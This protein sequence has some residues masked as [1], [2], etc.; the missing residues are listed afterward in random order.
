[1]EEYRDHLALE[2]LLIRYVRAVDAPD[3]N[4]EELLDLFTEDATL[5]GA[6][7]AEPYR[8]KKAIEKWVETNL[9]MRQ[10]VSMRHYVSNIQTEVS[11]DEGRIFAYLIAVYARP[12]METVDATETLYGEYECTARR[13]PDGWK[14]VNRVVR[15]DKTR[16]GASR[17]IH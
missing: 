15:L 11:G 16:A 13:T 1:M 10:E 12:I 17:Q 6:V 7:W 8:G 5:E 3:N 2:Q 14:L 4:A 9:L